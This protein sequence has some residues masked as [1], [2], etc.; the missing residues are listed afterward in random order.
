LQVTSEPAT[1]IEPHLKLTR[2]KTLTADGLEL[3]RL[4]LASS[5]RTWIDLDF[6]C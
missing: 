2:T 4:A 6:A 3:L 5:I 1:K